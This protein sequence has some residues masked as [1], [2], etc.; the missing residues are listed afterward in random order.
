MRQLL[1]VLEDNQRLIFS[2]LRQELDEL[3]AQ[4]REL[5]RKRTEDAET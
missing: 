1:T 3:E 4:E 5:E 2:L